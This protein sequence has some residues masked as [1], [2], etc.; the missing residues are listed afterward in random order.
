[1]ISDTVKKVKI[2][3]SPQNWEVIQHQNGYADFDVSGIFEENTC[4]D[5]MQEMPF[6]TDRLYVRIMCENDGS[7]PLPLTKLN[8]DGDTW[9]V[10]INRLPCG[11]PYTLDIVLFDD[12]ICTYQPVRGENIR[13]FCVGD[14]FLIAGQSN[15]SGM[16]RGV[17]TDAPE[18]GVH[19]LRNMDFWDIASAPFDEFD[20]SKHSMFI[21]FAKKLKNLVGRP[22]GLIPAAMGGSSISRW[23]P[24]ENGDL[25]HKT[26]KITEEKNIKFR[27]VLWYQGCTEAGNGVSKDE[28]LERFASM[29]DRFRKD[30]SSPDLPFF[31]FQL[32]RQIIRDRNEAL[33]RSYGEIREAQRLA[34]HS[35]DGVYVLPSIDA[36]HMSDFI[37]SSK[38]SAVMLGDRL[39][40]QVLN[41]LYGIGAGVKVPEIV[42]AIKNSATKI[43]VEF[44]GVEGFLCDFNSPLDKYPIEIEDACGKAELEKVSLSHSRVEL[45]TK[46]ELTDPVYVSG[47]TG[48]DPKYIMTDI[49]SNVPMLCFHRFE[50]K[51]IKKN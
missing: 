27:A 17:L 22:I 37:H 2:L 24:A 5:T 1:M 41:V 40:S 23:N 49:S 33:D 34:A 42:S 20:Y 46:N 21:S 48:T 4:D 28:Y 31:T 12:E 7:Q 19:V 8:T 26:K 11:G 47:Q 44:D 14:V 29:V 9:N 35:V 50:V 45:Y 25:Y 6:S 32:N 36:L 43:V 30:F 39:A 38:A 16:G 3:S 18:I 13:H 51:S 10:C 15:A